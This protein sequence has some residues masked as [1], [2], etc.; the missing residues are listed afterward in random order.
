MLGL[1]HRGWSLN[2]YTHHIVHTLRERGY[3]SA[4]I[5]EQHISKKPDVIGYDEVVK[6]ETTRAD[7]VAPAAD[8]FLSR[9]GDDPFFLSVG[10]FETHR[11]FLGP[12]VGARHP[13]RAAA[14]QPPRHARDP[15]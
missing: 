1:A 12:E 3:R 6:I 2:D 13:L 14:A 15:P 7:Q 10:F 5:G 11:E 9:Q 4:L 8:E